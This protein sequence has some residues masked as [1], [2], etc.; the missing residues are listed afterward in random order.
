VPENAFY[1]PLGNGLK[2]LGRPLRQF[3]D[4]TMQRLSGKRLIFFSE[5]PQDLREM[6]RK[7]L[8]IS[9]A[10]SHRATAKIYI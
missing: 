10:S 4:S 5:I 3:P 9:R 8:H 6:A 2:G 7:F 1:W